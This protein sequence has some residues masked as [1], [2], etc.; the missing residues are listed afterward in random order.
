MTTTDSRRFL[1]KNAIA[2]FVRASHIPS[3]AEPAWPI[4]R[5]DKTRSALEVRTS[6]R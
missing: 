3:I 4:S 6:M 1:R 2:S 5:A